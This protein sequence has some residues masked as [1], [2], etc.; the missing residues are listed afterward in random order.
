MSG[1]VD[2]KFRHFEQDNEYKLQLNLNHGLK[3]P[4]QSNV[5]VNAAAANCSLYGR[6]HNQQQQQSRGMYCISY[7]YTHTHIYIYIYT[8]WLI[9]YAQRYASADNV[10]ERRNLVSK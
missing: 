2:G 10:L 5:A 4:M 8:S 1:G 3:Y 6:L 9:V 7:L